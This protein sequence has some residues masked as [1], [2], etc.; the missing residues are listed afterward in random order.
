MFVVDVCLGFFVKR[1][2]FVLASVCVLA[3][4]SHHGL[5]FA[6]RPVCSQ[7][8]ERIRAATPRGLRVRSA[9]CSCDMQGMYVS[10]AGSSFFWHLLVQ[11]GVQSSTFMFRVIGAVFLLF[12]LVIPQLRKTLSVDS[13]L[14]FDRVS[15]Q[16]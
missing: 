6:R 4:E 8:S 15:T 1:E 13:F 12:L 9:V 5:S 2:G 14:Q 16:L 10:L 7:C 3:V 11:H